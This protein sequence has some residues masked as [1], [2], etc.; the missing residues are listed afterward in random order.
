MNAAQVI[1]EID[2][3]D[4]TEQGKVIDYIHELEELKKLPTHQ[5]SESKEG[6]D[7]HPIDF[8]DIMGT[9]EDDPGFDDAMNDFERIDEELWK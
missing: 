2:A 5:E 7:M 8:S 9:W 3:L 1:K 6:K 4:E